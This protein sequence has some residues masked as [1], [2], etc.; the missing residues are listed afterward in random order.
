[1]KRRVGGLTLSIKSSSLGGRRGAFLANLILIDES[2]CFRYCTYSRMKPATNERKKGSVETL[3][4]HFVHP[5]GLSDEGVLD[6]GE[7]DEHEL[8]LRLDGLG[9]LEAEIPKEVHNPHIPST[10]DLP[11]NREQ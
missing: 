6:E 3:T 8:V 2:T 9:S 7:V 10:Q 11:A 5:D 1:M 4:V